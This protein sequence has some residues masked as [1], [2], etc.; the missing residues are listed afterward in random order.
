MWLTSLFFGPLM[1]KTVLLLFSIWWVSY[2]FAISVAFFFPLNFLTVGMQEFLS[3]GNLLKGILWWNGQTCVLFCFS[4]WWKLAHCFGS[5]RNELILLRGHS[6]ASY[7]K[8]PKCK[9]N[10]FLQLMFMIAPLDRASHNFSQ[11]GTE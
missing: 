10:S 7:V 9:V 1:I 11:N 5:Q 3:V 6:L 8:D 2:L 4:H